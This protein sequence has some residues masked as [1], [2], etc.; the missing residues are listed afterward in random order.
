M[1]SYGIL[2]VEMNLPMTVLDR[3]TKVVAIIPMIIKHNSLMRL[4][5]PSKLNT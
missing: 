1:V 2:L 4:I 3:Q 5:T